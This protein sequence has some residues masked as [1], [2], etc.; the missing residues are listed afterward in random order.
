MALV[1]DQAALA[2][3]AAPAPAAVEAGQHTAGLAAAAVLSLGAAAV[4][5]GFAPAHFEE[6]TS[7]GAFFL[8]L[9]LLQTA[10]AVA[11]LLWPSRRVAALGL[12]QLGV[13]GVWAASRSVGLPGVAV[14]PVGFP[15]SLAT[16]FELAI[17]ALCGAAVV[18][19]A[20]GRS[21]GRGRAAAVLG[22]AVAGATLVALTPRFAGAHHQHD[23]AAGIG[24]GAAAAGPSPCEQAGKPA[25]P[26]QVTDTQGHFHR[27]PR[28]QGPLDPATRQTLAVQ[29]VQARGVADKYPTVGEAER[30]GYRMSTPYVP[31]IGAHYTSIALVGRF[32]PAAPSEL[33]FDGTK[34][35]AK[36][37]GLSYLVY[38]PGGAPAGFAGPNDVWHQHNA[39]GGLCFNGDGVVIAGEEST[40]PQCRALGGAKRELDDVWMLHDWVVPGWECSWGVFAPECPELGGRVGGTAWDRPDPNAVLPPG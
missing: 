7:H 2:T 10:W 15:D 27:G 26:A 5:F 24:T 6:R 29:Q 30:A 17:A 9:A 38:H 16:A 28:P 35:D 31:C 22:A 32:D 13:V 39:N 36:L 1:T 20:G 34:P 14:E 11:A 8:G 4:H 19:R 3:A 37:V 33:L 12:L 23:A 40:A 18:G 21:L 25:S